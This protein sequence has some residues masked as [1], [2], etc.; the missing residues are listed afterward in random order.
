MLYKLIT[1]SILLSLFSCS[2]VKKN[3]REVASL[4]EVS[5]AEKGACIEIIKTFVG[6]KKIIKKKGLGEFFP[7]KKPYSTE[8]LEIS[9]KLS[10]NYSNRKFSQFD[11]E[12]SFNKFQTFSYLKLSSDSSKEIDP[13]EFNKWFRMNATE[14]GDFIERGN[15]F[16]ETLDDLITPFKKWKEDNGFS[17]KNLKKLKKKSPEVIE[18]EKLVL[19]AAAEDYNKV[20]NKN[21][22]S[23]QN[24]DE[25]LEDVS[26][27]VS[28]FHMIEE[29]FQGD[30]FYRWM[31]EN[32]ILSRELFNKMKS[33]VK[34][35]DTLGDFL[36]GNYST[37]L[38]FSKQPKGPKKSVREKIQD[39]AYKMFDKKKSV[40]E[41]CGDDADCI[42][43]ESRSFF[44][45]LIGMEKFKKSFSCLRQFPMA[46]NA[47]Y[48]D[49][50]VTWA[51]LGHMYKS[52]E[53]EFSR[54]PW[55]VATNGLIFTPIMS[56][57]NCQ[58]SFQTRNAFGGSVDL[59]KRL[60][61]TKNFLRSWR[62]MAGVSLVSGVSLVGLGIGYNELYA[63]MGAPVE[64]TEYLREQMKLLPF[65]FMW[66]GVLG[67]LGNLTV[68]NPIKYK[69]IP[70]I[71]TMIQSKTGVAAAGVTGLTALNFAFASGSE[72]Y[73]SFAFNEIWRYHFLPVFLDIAGYDGPNDDDLNGKMTINAFDENSDIYVTEYEN[74]V[75]T[76]VVVEK[77]YDENGKEYIKVEDIDLEIPNYILEE[78]VEDIP[79]V[80]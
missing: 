46:R 70:K 78:S 62:R 49:F 15:R 40:M 50:V 29:N 33:N 23:Y 43:R 44:E 25:F 27:S 64:N 72:Y 63:S 52:N 6:K 16:D 42:A 80:E 36:S 57:I 51:M 3:N 77:S 45:R 69:L 2:T 68:A 12:E 59:T 19:E 32:E 4:G 76:K 54:F 10:S 30:D 1:L 24:Y 5:P 47:M 75:T 71:A 13:V 79:K 73:Q 7:S 56:E 11:Q 34:D 67:G 31:S 35:Q 58:A 48:V 22:S 66:S 38:P 60:S 53:E 9:N 61:R 39:F 21:L 74:G 20:V 8:K 18:A 14:V 41:A 26:S 17:F 37:F 65:M 55:E 28:N